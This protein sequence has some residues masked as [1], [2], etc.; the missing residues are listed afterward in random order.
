MPRVGITAYDLLISCPNDVMSYV[1]VIKECI[2]NFNRT[3]GA[4]NN[5]EIVAKHWS[6]DSYP[7]S[8]DTPQE[9]LNKQF[10]RDCDAAVALFWTKFGTPTDKY[11][12]GTEEEIV[13][14]LN[15][16]KQVFMYFLDAQIN[17]SELDTDQYKKVQAFKK[18]YENQGIYC[19]VTDE[20]DLR[21]N[22]TNHLTKHFLPLMTGENSYFQ[23]RP[24]P[25][26]KIK[27]AK[28]ENET[29]S[30]IS[31]YNYLECKK[32]INIEKGII[33]HILSLQADCLP[34]RDKKYNEYEYNALGN[35]DNSKAMTLKDNGP[36][37][38][39][40]EVDAD[41]PEI[42]KDT[43]TEFSNKH[44]I[45][46][47]PQFWN[48][49]NLKRYAMRIAFYD[50]GD[51]F[52]GTEEEK[53]RYNKIKELYYDILEYKEY[54][55]FF[56]KID[57]HK[58]VNLVVT[59][60]GNTFDEDID[61]K[62][63]LDKDCILSIEEIPIP[64]R[65]I[66]EAILDNKFLEHAYEIEESDTIESYTDYD[67]IPTTYIPDLPITSPTKKYKKHKEQFKAELERIF[68]YQHFTKEE[69]DIITFHIDYLKHNKAIAFPSSLVFK[70]APKIIKYEITSKYMSNVAK[71][72]IKIVESQDN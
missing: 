39:H 9:L 40:T 44:S 52:N 69:Y 16:H 35:I 56:T 67:W 22:F 55:N 13:E 66:I 4:V 50:N 72:Q 46:I 63:I 23:Q 36:L 15:A 31:N 29:E 5:A 41:I 2:D 62:L 49:G 37:T 20:N 26:L 6:T 54:T 68:H 42:W 7:Q 47:E 14:M 24:T 51:S 57:Q 64:G 53:E 65:N 48:I 11:G 27:D 8:G 58:F 3:I 10:V 33:A 61:I 1:D 12:S 28:T 32:I 17:P 43:I 19:V 21:K 34:P 70:K 60:D 71:G 59:N 38:I 25:N 18:K 45:S 30:V